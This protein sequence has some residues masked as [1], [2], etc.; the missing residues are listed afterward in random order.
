MLDNITVVNTS[1]P[2]GLDEL[3]DPDAVFIGGSSG[4]LTPIISYCF[5]RLKKGGRL[6]MN[7]VVLENLH[8]GIHAFKEAG[9]EAEVVQVAISKEKGAGSLKILA[10]HN[11]V[12][13]LSSGKGP[14]NS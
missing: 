4:E 7:T 1:A 11:P 3:P 2:G 6:A 14:L 13:I 5:Q 10:S 9:A 8:E 12:F